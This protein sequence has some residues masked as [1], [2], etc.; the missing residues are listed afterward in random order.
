MS[1]K[2]QNI[3]KWKLDQSA[4]VHTH[5]LNMHE[6]RTNGADSGQTF[7]NINLLCNTILKQNDG[8]VINEKSC[9]HSKPT[10]LTLL[11]CSP[12]VPQKSIY[13]T[14][15]SVNEPDYQKKQRRI[16]EKIATDNSLQ[17]NFFYFLI[18]YVNA[19]MR[20]FQGCYAK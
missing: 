14:M 18:L 1:R 11:F 15:I 16:L 17:V 3:L 5:I 7:S 19:H 4:Q 13:I 9:N 2:N 12:K 8:L 6:K 20:N 10:A